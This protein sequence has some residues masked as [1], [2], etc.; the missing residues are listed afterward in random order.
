M[1]QRWVKGGS[2]F[3]AL[4]VMIEKTTNSANDDND[5]EYEVKMRGEYEQQQQQ[6]TAKEVVATEWSFRAVL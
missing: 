2:S 5:I 4:Q 1:V 6:Q 3:V